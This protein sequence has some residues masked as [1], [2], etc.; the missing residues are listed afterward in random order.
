MEFDKR[1]VSVGWSLERDEL[2]SEWAVPA[3]AADLEAVNDA[4]EQRSHHLQ[5]LCR[6]HGTGWAGA[7]SWNEEASGRT[8]TEPWATTLSSSDVSANKEHYQ[9][10]P[11]RYWQWRCAAKSSPRK[12]KTQLSRSSAGAMSVCEPRQG[13][14]ETDEQHDERKML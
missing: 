13:K 3:D 8:S 1:T 14:Q 10:G 9:S 11:A 7:A 2:Q 5:Q 6:K 12:R 4:F